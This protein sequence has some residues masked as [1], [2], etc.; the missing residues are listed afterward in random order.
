MPGRQITSAK[1]RWTPNAGELTERQVY[2]LLQHVSGEL[3]HELGALL[4]PAGITAEQYQVLSVLS[5]AG[6]VGVPLNLIAQR[7][8]AGDPDVTRLI[9]RLEEHGLAR[10]ERDSRDRR[11]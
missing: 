5:D 3:I 10:R 6:A 7:S 1:R 11:V 9:D 2:L 8:P 4:K